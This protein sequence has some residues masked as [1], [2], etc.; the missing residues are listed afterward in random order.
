MNGTRD[1]PVMF[2]NFSS[3]RINFRDRS[4]RGRVVVPDLGLKSERAGAKKWEPH[5]KISSHHNFEI[6]P[7]SN[8]VGRSSKVRDFKKRGL[9]MHMAQVRR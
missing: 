4:L 1:P 8:I 6:L 2:R 9:S 3:A 7:C 5:R